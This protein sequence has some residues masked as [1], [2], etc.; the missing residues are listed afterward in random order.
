MWWIPEVYETFYVFSDD[1]YLRCARLPID[2]Q[3]DSSRDSSLDSTLDSTSVDNMKLYLQDTGE[4][5]TTSI[6]NFYFGTTFM[7]PEP[8]RE[9]HGLAVKCVWNEIV[10]DI[11]SC[12]ED[13]FLENS[14]FQKFTFEV[15]KTSEES[16]EVNILPYDDNSE[17]LLSYEELN[18]ENLNSNIC[19]YKEVEEE[20]VDLKLMPLE[21]S[22]PEEILL[23]SQNFQE[24]DN[25]S[26]SGTARVSKDLMTPEQLEAWLEEP[27]NTEDPEV[28]VDG[29]KTQDDYRRCR[30][31]DPAIGG[32][33]KGGRCKQIHVSEVDGSSRD[34]KEVTLNIPK[35]LPVPAVGTTLEVQVTRYK[36][37]RSLVCRYVNQKSTKKDIDGKVLFEHMN[38]MNQIVQYKLMT[39]K[40]ALKQLVIAKIDSSFYRCRVEDYTSTDSAFEVL[41]LDY[42]LLK[43]VHMKYLYSWSPRFDYYPFLTIEIAIANIQPFTNDETAFRNKLM[44]IIEESGNRLKCL[45][46]ENFCDIEC[47]LYNDKCEDIGRKLID[48]GFV[49]EKAL[50]APTD[51]KSSTFFPG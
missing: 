38:L 34:S 26:N 40:P 32:C 24:N 12:S 22:V 8:L 10:V 45:V 48:W 43:K 21:P 2:E 39:E 31:Y 17:E 3:S 49:A 35:T 33:F 30:F 25:Q 50:K 46:V 37:V 6:K 9:V 44:D 13:S 16:L 42:G 29:Y 14:V 19:E 28:A 51:L 23:Q 15:I 18:E 5:L 47:L 11:P 1:I 20:G 27:L 41:M 4:T 36:S 7:I